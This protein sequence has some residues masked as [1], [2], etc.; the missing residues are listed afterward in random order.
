MSSKKQYTR[1]INRIPSGETPNSISPKKTK[2][3]TPSPNKNKSR[4]SMNAAMSI[5]ANMDYREN[6]EVFNL[7]NTNK[8]YKSQ[9]NRINELQLKIQ[10]YQSKIN[11][12]EKLINEND[13]DIDMIKGKLYG[14]YNDNNRIDNES[15]LDS[16][17]K[18]ELDESLKMDLKKFEEKQKKYSKELDLYDGRME[19]SE[20]LLKIWKSTKIT[21]DKK[22]ELEKEYIEEY[23]KFN[24]NYKIIQN[25]IDNLQKQTFEKTY[26]NIKRNVFDVANH[27]W[28]FDSRKKQKLF[29]DFSKNYDSQYRKLSREQ[30]N[31][32]EDFYTNY[33]VKIKNMIN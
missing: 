9:I 33:T 8:Q 24:K 12:L 14:R 28:V 20:F 31:L 26:P 17:S 21:N 11:E 5:L 4:K 18:K 2:S 29:E 13:D 3:K 22:E 27:Q 6:P 23:R 15:Y 10:K 16:A 25:K 1:K 32:D 19:E 30:K 7:L